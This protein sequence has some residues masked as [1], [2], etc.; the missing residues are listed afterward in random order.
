MV[1]N[2]LNKIRGFRSHTVN[3]KCEEDQQVMEKLEDCV[4]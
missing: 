1:E 2:R 4:R 3:G